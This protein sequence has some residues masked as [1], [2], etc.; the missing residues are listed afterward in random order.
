ML[1]EA[2]N[3]SSGKKQDAE[4][5]GVHKYPRKNQPGKFS[6][7]LVL[8]FKSEKDGRPVVTEGRKIVSE[9][10]AKSTYGEFKIELKA[11]KAK[12]D[13]PKKSA[14]KKA[15]APKKSAPRKKAAPKVKLDDAALC[16]KYAAAQKAQYLDFIG[17]DEE[18]ASDF[19]SLQE[20][21]CKGAR[22]SGK[23]VRMPAKKRS[24]ASLAK[25]AAKRSVTRAKKTGNKRVKSGVSAAR[26]ASKKC[27]DARKAHKAGVYTVHL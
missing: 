26:A 24:C 17:D 25:S 7:M 1:I 23:R 3:I 22:L 9:A 4:V 12:S 11:P 16:A 6:Y 2:H 13:K 5:L 18:E 21:K 10:E 20:L 27:N 15:A 19:A 8:R 14:P